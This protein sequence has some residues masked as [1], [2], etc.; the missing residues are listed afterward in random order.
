[1]LHMA[2]CRQGARAAFA[3]CR[4]RHTPE[5][6]TPV[7]CGAPLRAS[8]IAAGPIGNEALIS[9]SGDGSSAGAGASRSCPAALGAGLRASTNS[10]RADPAPAVAGVGRTP[11]E[12]SQATRTWFRYRHQLS[13]VHVST[14]RTALGGLMGDGATRRGWQDMDVTVGGSASGWTMCRAAVPAM[15]CA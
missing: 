6:T 14:E 15:A 7:L 13:A 1:M 2:C 12:R 3:S 10:R 5:V 11:K 8:T 4:G 9:Q